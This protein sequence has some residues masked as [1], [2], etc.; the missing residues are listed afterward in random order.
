MF[1]EKNLARAYKTPIWLRKFKSILDISIQTIIIQFQL[2]IYTI[3]L[4][5][6]FLVYGYFRFVKKRLGNR[7]RVLRVSRELSQENM[8]AELGLSIGAYSNIERGITDISVSRLYR[9]AE[10]LNS[11]VFDL[12]DP[13][14]KVENVLQD[15]GNKYG[16]EMERLREM[17][18]ELKNEVEKLK[19]PS[20][21][22]NRRP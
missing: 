13:N 19:K 8:A 22:N 11:S 4:E 7:I 6:S 14:H 20:K 5:I 1:T 2:K 3:C 16:E 18:L 15:T 9:I 12:L 17:V 21:S 10:I